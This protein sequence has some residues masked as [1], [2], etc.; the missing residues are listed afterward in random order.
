MDVYLSSP[1]EAVLEEVLQRCPEISLNILVTI[2][3][4]PTNFNA[5]MARYEGIIRKLAL[6]SGPFSN[7]NS[8]LGITTSQLF[9]RLVTF[10][11]ANKGRFDIMFS[12]DLNFEPDGFEENQAYLLELEEQ[13]LPVVPV[14]HN[15]QNHEVDTLIQAGYKYVAIGRQQNKTNPNVLFPT[16][17]KLHSHGVKTHLLGITDYNLLVGCPATS[18]DSKSWLDDANTGVVRF[19]NPAKPGENKTDVLYFPDKQGK[20]KQGTHVYT[21]YEYLDEFEGFLG[22]YGLTLHDMLGLRAG[23]YR[24]FLGI[25]YYRTLEDVVT[26][27]HRTNPLFL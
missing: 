17:F 16:V 12:Y 13:G 3:R 11:R 8:N 27:S 22:N 5:F 10:G 21:Q 1:G 15:M 20:T 6:D 7:N 19:W 14:T 2:A 26:E 23:I 25:I 9:M 18:C 4:M 24:Q